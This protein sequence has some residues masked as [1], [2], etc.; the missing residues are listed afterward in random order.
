MPGKTIYV[1]SAVL[2]LNWWRRSPKGNGSDSSCWP[3][4]RLHFSI[5]HRRLWASAAWIYADRPATPFAIMPTVAIL[6]GMSPVQNIT[7]GP[8]SDFK[9]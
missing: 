8:K 5:H 2:L 6:P 9:T 7:T 1:C 4:F 3:S